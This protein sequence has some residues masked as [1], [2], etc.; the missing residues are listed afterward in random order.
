LAEKPVVDFFESRPILLLELMPNYSAL[1]KYAWYL[2]ITPNRMFSL[3]E[4]PILGKDGLPLC[5]L[6]GQQLELKEVVLVD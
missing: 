4:Y 3:G 6:H 5:V 1:N 2:D